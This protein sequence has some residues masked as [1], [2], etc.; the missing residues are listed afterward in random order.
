VSLSAGRIVDGVVK[1]VINR[2]FTLH[3]A[4]LMA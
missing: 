2:G 4:P 1:A 3:T